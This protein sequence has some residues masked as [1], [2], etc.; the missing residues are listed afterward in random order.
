MIWA[1]SLFF[2]HALGILTALQAI[3]EVRTPQGAA[4]W[5]VALI[6]FPYVTVPAYWIFGRTKFHGYVTSRRA[7]LLETVP[8]ARRYVEELKA[9]RLLAEPGRDQAMLVE[10]LAKL[11]FT[12]GNDTE[13]LMDG[14]AT[15]RS[16]FQGIEEAR[17]Y[18][19]IEFY[20]L[21][22]DVLGREL[23]CR[24]IAKARAGVRVALLFDELG[25]NGLPATYS[26]PL[27][28]AG[29]E[30]H[31]FNTRQGKRNFWQLNFR[32]HRKIVVVDGRTA[33]VGGHNVGDEYLG[34]DSR[35]GPWRDTHVKLTGP[36][37]ACV[38]MAFYEDWHWATGHLLSL[39]WEACP[40]A[41]RENRAVLCLPSGPADA[42]ETCTLFFLNVI[43]RAEKQLWIASP[44]FVPDEQFISALQLAALRG[45]D[46][47]IIIPEHSDNL[48]AQLSAWAAI[49][50]LLEAGVKVYRYQP[51][52]MHQKVVL[53]D[54]L[55][56]M[57]GT[58]NFDNR[59][60]R[61]NFEITTATVDAGFGSDVRKMLE[62]DM[63]KSIA[64]TREA[65]QARGF[66]RRAASRLA[67]LTA[68]VQ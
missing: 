60:F 65:Y 62:A 40:A 22:D 32:N 41:N 68:P 47:R 5:A 8:M 54:D 44:Y 30:I 23:Q 19:L 24:L 51:G 57:I 34:R 48:L 58:A 35:I 17:E 45:V 28:A 52:F 11:P 6:S 12:T 55:Y 39:R 53:V 29:V 37:V 14:E 10:R 42:L 26:A 33:W 64:E 67:S 16:I 25:S 46:L 38:Q 9:Q 27:T 7:H 21:R 59:S 66:W 18:I 49:G 36:V 4:A 20:I 3:M 50:S 13:L 63:E 31:P 61:L 43:H 56:S 2:L 1:L 15:F